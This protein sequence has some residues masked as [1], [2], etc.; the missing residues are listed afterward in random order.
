LKEWS[1]TIYQHSH[2]NTVLEEKDQS[3]DIK[4]VRTNFGDISLN[5]IQDD[6]DDEGSEQV[7]F[8]TTV[9]CLKQCHDTVFTASLLIMVDFLPSC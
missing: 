3:G 6:H 1:Y 8:L 2:G 5:F 4:I 7:H 9:R